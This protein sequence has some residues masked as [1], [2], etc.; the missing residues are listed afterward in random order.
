M[1]LKRRLA[2]WYFNHVPKAIS[3]R[4]YLLTGWQASRMRIVGKNSKGEP[5]TYERYLWLRD[6]RL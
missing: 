1:R 3:G 6:S 4:I 5:A 2:K